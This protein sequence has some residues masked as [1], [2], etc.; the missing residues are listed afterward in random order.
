M[1]NFGKIQI[2]YGN[3]I[4]GR[5][6]QILAGDFDFVEYFL[7]CFIE[8]VDFAKKPIF[9]IFYPI[10]IPIATS[11]FWS[12][13]YDSSSAFSRVIFILSHTFL[14]LNQNFFHSL[15]TP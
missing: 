3:S 14:S 6:I 13:L 7:K 4:F 2:V 11:Y 5:E 8:S 15:I 9:I 1:Q 12:H 10:F